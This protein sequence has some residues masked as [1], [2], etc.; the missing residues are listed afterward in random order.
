L[1]FMRYVQTEGVVYEWDPL[2]S[3]NETEGHLRF[4]LSSFRAAPLLEF[5]ISFDFLV[6]SLS[7]LLFSA[8]MSEE[9]LSPSF[10][11]LL[12]SYCL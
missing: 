11:V 3:I 8:H 4:L 1:A 12:P 9:S 10:Y 7:L 2:V 5:S 6:F